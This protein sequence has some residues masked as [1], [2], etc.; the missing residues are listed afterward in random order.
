MK[1]IAIIFLLSM[2]ILSCQ[3]SYTNDEEE[4]QSTTVST[5]IPVCNRD[6]PV[7]VDSLLNSAKKTIDIM[8]FEM[9]FYSGNSVRELEDDLCSAVLKGVK[10]N[11]LLDGS[12]DENYADN[13]ETAD[14]LVS[15]G[16]NIK[17]DPAGIT[18]HS[19]LI[20]IDST[21]VVV[22]S[23]NWSY[24]A[25]ESNNETNVVITD[26]TTARYFLDYFYNIWNVST[27]Y[28]KGDL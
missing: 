26:T 20:I 7:V 6:Y 4:Q 21:T 23:T 24:S 25:F 5:I 3:P 12:F 17:F 28:G 18:T 27:G 10:V 15:N 14:Y 1:K 16:V 22:G 19:K 8:M 9:Y 11:V 2:F 13:K